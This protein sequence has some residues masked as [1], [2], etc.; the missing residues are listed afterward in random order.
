M[1][2]LCSINLISGK[3][4]FSAIE[5]IT[6]KLFQIAA[7]ILS[8]FKSSITTW[9]SNM[10]GNSPQLLFDVS[11][12]GLFL[13]HYNDTNFIPSHWK[14]S[15][16]APFLN[17]LSKMD[18][19]D[20]NEIGEKLNIQNLASQSRVQ[21]F[22]QAITTLYKQSKLK[23]E[24]DFKQN[25]W[26]YYF[27][28]EI[29]KEKKLKKDPSTLQTSSSKKEITRQYTGKRQYTCKKCDQIKKGHN[30]NNSKK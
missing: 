13:K 15:F 17:N 23:E 1:L 18:K 27:P 21:V 29:K 7:Q 28:A 26:A 14:I 11:D 4:I 5:L 12:L 25:I 20:W 19:L 8:E 30:C 10:K 24:D 3:I 6:E 16:I 22:Y 9:I 2:I